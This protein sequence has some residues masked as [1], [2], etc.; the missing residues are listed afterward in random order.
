MKKK[1]N[2]STFNTKANKIKLNFVFY[3]NCKLKK[4]KIISTGCLKTKF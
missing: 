1:Q 4:T 3:F 2:L